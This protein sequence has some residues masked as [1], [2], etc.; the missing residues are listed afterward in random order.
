MKDTLVVLLNQGLKRFLTIFYMYTYIKKIVVILAILML[1]ISVFTISCNAKQ[2]IGTQKYPEA[3]EKLIDLVEGI[4][5]ILKRETS[6]SIP[7]QSSPPH[8]FPTFLGAS[9]NSSYA[10]ISFSNSS[11]VIPI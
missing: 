3:L 9:T 11:F 2:E 5:E 6:V 7:I 10:C 1:G 4:C 8:L